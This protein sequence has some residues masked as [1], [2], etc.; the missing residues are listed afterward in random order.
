M[1][2]VSNEELKLELDKTKGNEEIS[3][4]LKE[5]LSKDKNATYNIKIEYDENKLAKYIN[6]TIAPRN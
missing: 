6:L 5:F 1:K 3:E 2:V 4:V